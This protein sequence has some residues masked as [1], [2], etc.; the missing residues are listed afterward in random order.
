MTT[1]KIITSIMVLSGILL[2]QCSREEINQ[3][4]ALPVRKI[5][6][7]LYTTKDFSNQSDLITFKLVI[8]KSAAVLWDST[9]APMSLKDIPS[10]SNKI[11][12]T[13]SVPNNDPSLLKV[14]FEYEIKNV[15]ISWHYDSI[16]TNKTFKAVDFDFQ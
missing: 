7:T 12:L 8:K 13:K 1:S 11:V 2:C 3:S 9:F 15:G 16:A 4:S 6:F 5:Q 10:A 14:G